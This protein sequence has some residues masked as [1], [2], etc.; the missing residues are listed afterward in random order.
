MEEIPLFCLIVGGEGNPF[1]VDINDKK[2]VGHLK[3]KIKE[4]K[5]KLQQYDADELRLYIG[6]KN[7][8]KNGEW[9]VR[10]EEHIKKLSK[11]DME[12][13][14]ADIYLNEEMEMDTM[15][16]LGKDW[17]KEPIDLSKKEIHVLVK[18]PS[19]TK[20]GFFE[21]ND[22]RK[23]KSRVEDIST[24]VEQL[25]ETVVMKFKEDFKEGMLIHLPGKVFGQSFYK[26]LYIR[27][28]YIYLQ[29]IINKE[30]ELGE[31]P[32]EKI[33]IIGSPG[34][35]KSV[36]GVYLF[37]IGMF[38]KKNVAYLN[39]NFIYYFTWMGSEYKVTKTPLSKQKYEGY[40]D[41]KE[42]DGYDPHYFNR[43]Y[44][45]ASPRTENYNHFKKDNCIRLY[46]NPWSKEECEAFT[47]LIVS[48]D[49]DWLAKFD[50]VGG[51]PRYLFS[52]EYEFDALRDGVKKCIPSNL[53]DLKKQIKSFEQRVL[54]DEMK[55]LLYSLYRDGTHP[56][57]YFLMYSS[58]AIGVV[59]ENQFHIHSVA[60]IRSWLRTSHADLQAWRGKE[61]E[62]Y[63]LLD[64]AGKQF[65]MRPLEDKNRNAKEKTYGPLGA[66]SMII[67]AAS[68]IKNNDLKLYVP[69]S[70]TFPAIDGVFI[71]PCTNRV[72]YVQCTVSK[73][74]P[75]K[76]AHL[77]HIYQNL[78]DDKR[79]GDEDT[80]FNFKTYE[81]ILLFLVTD[82]VY[83]NFTFQKY[84]GT[85]G[86]QEI[87]N[88]K[89]YVGKII[90]SKSKLLYE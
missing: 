3:E 75:I 16:I 36:F 41:G 14:I 28:E 34:I 42:F 78:I 48:Y 35:G 19:K 10:G 60:E 18:L 87:K 32:T 58:L 21:D 50:L 13:N 43:L 85:T 39:T 56:S 76:S 29:N 6:K 68:D 37:F 61:I 23:K 9:L 26:G 12:Q 17:F 55:H 47:N 1:P 20:R 84:E 64:I 65:T 77:K 66:E 89:Q 71:I 69:L 2:T 11:P 40:V 44:L 22:G 52:T 27:E 33:L 8:D 70:K 73:V 57:I 45:F 90:N 63:L 5:K 24:E 86:K 7:K 67:Y 62:K 46:M 4:K 83:D 25:W 15:D 79:I 31:T 59:M 82:D 80:G 74:H 53:D 30:I 72:V 54:E 51:K 88:I 49:K 38:E 81:H